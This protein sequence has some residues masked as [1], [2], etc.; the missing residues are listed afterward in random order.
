MGEMTLPQILVASLAT[1][2]ALVWI[3]M[4]TNKWHLD[5]KAG[6]E[7]LYSIAGPIGWPRLSEALV[8]GLC[9]FALLCWERHKL[10]HK[11]YLA[12]PK[13]KLKRAA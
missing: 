8:Q 3:C 4:G 12:T 9:L 7:F 13:Q 5:N 1:L 10:F 2:G 6:S 11:P